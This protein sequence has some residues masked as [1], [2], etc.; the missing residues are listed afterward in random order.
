MSKA[1][2]FIN[3][4]PPDQLPDMTG[5][6]LIACTDGALHYLEKLGLDLTCLDLI[7]GDF[8]SLDPDTQA[9]Y[10]DRLVV[11]RDQDKTDFQKLLEL[12]MQRG[13]SHIDVYGASG[14][15][16]DHYLGNL[17]AAFAYR[18][19]AE[20]VFHDTYSRYFFIPNDFACAGKKDAT[21]SLVP[22]PHARNVTTGGLQWLLNGEDLALTGRLGTRNIATG[23]TITCRYDS[24]DILLFLHY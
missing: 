9:R 13:V 10:Q 1:L 20:I 21:V 24:G 15:E 19:Q 18:G 23:E 6:R 16:Q 17:T 4:L 12:V 5:Y 2:V 22:F 8:D 7:S 14:G 3:G 11:T